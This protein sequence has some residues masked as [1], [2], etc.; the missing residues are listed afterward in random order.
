MPAAATAAG[1]ASGFFFCRFYLESSFCIS[2]TLF[3]G[4]CCSCYLANY[5]LQ[6]T[7]FLK[8]RKRERE[9]KKEKTD[10]IKY[11]IYTGGKKEEK[12]KNRKERK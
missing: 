4:P 2:F 7:L 5:L 1:A 6:L 11:N 3:V 12:K 9:R 8:V 10:R